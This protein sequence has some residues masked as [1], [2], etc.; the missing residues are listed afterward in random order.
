MNIPIITT[1]DIGNGN[2]REIVRLI[3]KDIP[4][5]IITLRKN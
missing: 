3:P 4:N 1:N 2:S 5:H